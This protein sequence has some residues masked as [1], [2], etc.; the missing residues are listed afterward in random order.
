MGKIDHQMISLPYISNPSTKSS[1]GINKYLSLWDFQN[2]LLWHFV[3][4][5]IEN[6]LSFSDLAKRSFLS[7]S[8]LIIS[9]K[10]QAY[11]SMLFTTIILEDIEQLVILELSF[12]ENTQI[13]QGVDGSCGKALLP[14]D[15]IL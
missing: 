9:K 4:S 5:N 15:I 2:I 10:K 3:S 13:K 8:Y 11:L 7:L 12:V 14:F 6:V 1:S